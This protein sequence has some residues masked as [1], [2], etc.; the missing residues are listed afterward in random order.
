MAGTNMAVGCL[1][2]SVQVA[3][4]HERRQRAHA[5]KKSAERASFH[6]MRLEVY[7]KKIEAG[8]HRSPP[9]E[10]IQSKTRLREAVIAV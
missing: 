2:R 10:Q 9:S 8:I 3:G 5:Q 4:T 6:R 1:E 7:R